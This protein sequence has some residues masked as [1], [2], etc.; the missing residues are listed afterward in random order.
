MSQRTPSSLGSSDTLGSWR[1]FATRWRLSEVARDWKGPNACCGSAPRC[2]QRGADPQ[3]AFGPFQSLA[4]SLSRHLVAKRLHDPSVSE[5]PNEL[6][7]RWLIHQRTYGRWQG[8][9]PMNPGIAYPAHPPNEIRL[10]G[11]KKGV[12]TVDRRLMPWNSWKRNTSTMQP[13]H[14][15]CLRVLTW[16]KKRGLRL[17]KIASITAQPSRPGIGSSWKAK[18]ERFRN[19]MT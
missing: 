2:A 13:T 6:G 7:V 9:S 15:C 11:R 16:K 18:I 3:H 17:R 10:A 1:R 8:L 14:I 5:L 19:T 4:T 12:I